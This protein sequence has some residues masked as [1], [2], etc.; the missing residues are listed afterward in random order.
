M[1][2]PSRMPPTDASP[3]AGFTQ[4]SPLPD[5]LPA[6]PWTTFKAW[7]D[8]AYA[9]RVQP[10]TNAMTL[11]TVDAHGRPAAR[12]VLCKD[13]N[14]D[15]DAGYIVFHTN[16]KG[17]K[18]REIAANPYVAVVFHWDDLDR[19]VRIEG[20]VTLVPDAQSDAYFRTRPL[21][22]RIGAWASDQS[23]PIESREAL[24]EKIADVMARFGI[25]FDNLET[26]EIPRPPHW[27]GFRIWAQAVELWVGDVGRI[28]DR[29]RWTRSL[30]PNEGGFR[31]GPWSVQRLQP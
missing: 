22:R 18:G 20:P 3:S 2:S 7:F 25:G 28:H 17:R 11:A 30:T 27:G 4:D 24:L 16:H 31:P 1:E 14:L 12:I 23:E 5:P 21:D 26:A 29:A 6:E 13:M 19:Q 9:K 15:A 10:N 8:E